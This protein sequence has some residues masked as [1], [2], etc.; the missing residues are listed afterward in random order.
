[1]PTSIS[2]CPTGYRLLVQLVDDDTED[3]AREHLVRIFGER[4]GWAAIMRRGIHVCPE[5]VG[6]HHEHAG[7]QT[8]GY[9]AYLPVGWK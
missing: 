7:W 6:M 3:A 9:R 1:M 8:Y 4:K 5:L 2:N